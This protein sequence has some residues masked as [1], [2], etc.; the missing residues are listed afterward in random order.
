MTTFF[1]DTESEY[2]DY[3]ELVE[4]IGNLKKGKWAVKVDRMKR[5]DPANRRYWGMIV[6]AFSDTTGH[7]KDEIHQLLGKEFLSYEKILRDGKVHTF[8]RSTTS[9]TTVEFSAYCDKCERFGAG[10]GIEFQEDPRLLKYDN[11]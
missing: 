10:F 9:L 2:D 11:E 6:K 5:T 3:L 8:V 1:L 4:H 7:S